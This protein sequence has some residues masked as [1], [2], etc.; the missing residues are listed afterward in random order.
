[1]VRRGRA[2]AIGPRQGVGRDRSH[3]VGEELKWLA[4]QD[5]QDPF[6]KGLRDRAMPFEC[7]S[8]RFVSGVLWR[9]APVKH[10]KAGRVKGMVLLRYTISGSLTQCDPFGIPSTS[11]WTGAAI[12]AK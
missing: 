4:A 2:D 1:V 3:D 8:I 12:I 9:R 10:Y 11:H 6:W 7:P 5:L